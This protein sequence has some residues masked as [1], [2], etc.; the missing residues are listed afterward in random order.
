MPLSP[1]QLILRRG[2][3]LRCVTLSTGRQVVV[4]VATLAL[5]VWTGVASTA[6]FDRVDKLREIERQEQQISQLRATYREA[7]G[8]L[9][10]MQ[11][12]FD[13]VG[14]EIDRIE[15]SL[16][17]LADAPPPAGLRLAPFDLRSAAHAAGCGEAAMAAGPASPASPDGLGLPGRS[18]RYGAAQLEDA[19]DRL[20]DSHNQFLVY[21]N[22]LA[23]DHIGQ[24]EQALSAI[25]LDADRLLP[26]IGQ[27]PRFGRG[28]PFVPAAAAAPAAADTGWQFTLANL[29]QRLE[30]WD[31]LSRLIATVPLGAPLAE[32]E[33]TS[34]F[35]ARRDPINELTGF[36]EGI[37]LGA[38]DYTPVRSTGGGW[39]V[40]AGQRDRYGE[41]V[42]IDHGL[43]LHT[44]YAH[45]SC[46]FVKLGQR[47]DR[48]TV[49]GL[50]GQTGRTTGPHLHYEVRVDEQP[51]NPLKFMVAGQH[52]LENR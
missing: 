24:L 5:V 26:P 42:E 16:Q 13:K 8:R 47:V 44:R 15:G 35:G 7:F 12:T 40:Y 50:V 23:T 21:T 41:L 30:R 20:R 34:P 43:G 2:G 27:H 9:E 46:I 4:V 17:V 11:G 45:L 37:D 39:V 33:I 6:Y 10:E 29:N 3:Q 36:H 32:Y 25:G 51:Q 19:L 48:D 18:L 38:P 1:R 31:G 28:G 22:R 52:V 49:I 14:R